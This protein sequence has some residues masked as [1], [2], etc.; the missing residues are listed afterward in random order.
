M[1]DSE[2]FWA[3]CDGTTKSTSVA[4]LRATLSLAALPPFVLVWR[5]GFAEWL[6]AYLVSEFAK[7]LNVEAGDIGE[8]DPDLTEAPP[9]PVEW[10][11]ECFGGA[12]P[13]SLAEPVAG[14]GDTRDM[15]I[16]AKFDPQQMKTVLGRN[17]P[18]PI[19]AFRSVDDYLTHIQGLRS[20][21]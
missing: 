11:V 16:G 18:L 13:P 10:Y 19:A 12:P 20:K 1:N 8:T 5:A 6:P 4:A 15:K 9:A 17:K 21:R 7:I 3:D 2:W 14:M